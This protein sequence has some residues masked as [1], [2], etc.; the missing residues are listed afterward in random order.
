MASQKTTMATTTRR[1]IIIS[2]GRRF[3]QMSSDSDNDSDSDNI[4]T[5]LEHNADIRGGTRT[6]TKTKTKTKTITKTTKGGTAPRQ[7][8]AP[9]KQAPA[10]DVVKIPKSA[11]RNLIIRAGIKRLRVNGTKQSL[12]DTA[13]EFAER[14][15][16]RVLFDAMAVMNG[17]GRKT[18]LESDIKYALIMGNRR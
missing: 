11:I 18:I 14:Y 12:Y 17:D 10:S 9:R 16:Q 4:H 3:I 1:P 7:A 13:H 5:P 6:R 2:K 8:P 15:L